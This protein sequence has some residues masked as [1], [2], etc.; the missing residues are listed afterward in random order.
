MT[1]LTSQDLV[2]AGW[3]DQEDVLEPIRAE[4]LILEAK[5]IEDRKYLLK[6]LERRFPKPDLRLRLRAEPLPFAEAIEATNPVDEKNLGAVR[7][8]MKELMA[9]PVIEAGAIMPDACPAGG[10]P[11]NIPVGGAV[12]ARNAILPGGHGS[13]ICCSMYATIFREGGETEAMLDQL[14][15][16]TR[17]G[18]GGRPPGE[19]IPHPV[20]DEPVWNNRFL[21]GLQDHARAHMADQGDGNHFAFLGR[22][23]LGEEA[24]CRLEETG[25]DELARAIRDHGNKG[26]WRVLVTHHGSRGLGAHVYK[27]GLQAAIKQTAK[28]ASDIP[29][30]ACWLDVRTEEGADYWDALQYIGRWTLAN[31]QSIH[32]RFLERSGGVPVTAFGNQHNFVWKRGD[33]YLHGKGATPAW[34]DAAGRPL[35]GLIPLNMASPILLVLGR[36][37][38][39][40]LSFAPH[41]AGRNVSR[42]TLIRQFR[43]KDGSYDQQAM[44][45][46]LEAAVEGIGV[47]WFQGRADYS[48][49]PLGYKPA[50]QV[51][52]QIDQ[53]GLAEVIAEIQPLGSVMAGNGPGRD[54]EILT[55]K[56]KRQIQH[57]SDRRK[58]RQTLRPDSWDEEV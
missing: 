53:F 57:R 15:A 22:M 4:A 12:A 46:A 50:E 29:E 30:A 5:G 40:F 17:F 18:P 32:A 16:S 7:R 33:L 52:A 44:D 3:P 58:L 23:E 43:R 25:H 24:L 10:A 13:D 31:H 11:A 45:Q 48:E 26:E 51:R 55:P 8:F 49:G 1:S 34:N 20:N 2:D 27:R 36:D 56:Q 41:G 39:E 28:V 38:S 54:E 19:R 37:N 21:S 42:R 6:L 14:V 47:R 35:L 9:C